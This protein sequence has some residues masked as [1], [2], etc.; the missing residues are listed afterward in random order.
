M[1]LSVGAHKARLVTVGVLLCA[2]MI[3]FG[4]QHYA[5]AQQNIHAII[6]TDGASLQIEQP[7]GDSVI[8]TSEVMLSGSVGQANQLEVYVD[9]QIDSIVSLPVE[10]TTF[11]TTVQL[12]PGTRTIKIVAIDAC[13]S[14]NA[15][16]SIVM[17]YQPAVAASTGSATPTQIEGGVVIG[18]TPVSA[19]VPAQNPIER[20]VVGPLHSLADA[21]DLIP[22]AG[23][24]SPVGV[25]QP[26][27]LA[28]VAGGAALV[29]FSS[30]LLGVE[31]INKILQLV[32]LR[33]GLRQGYAAQLVLVTLGLMAVAMAF[34]L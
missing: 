7:S 20:I 33:I 27:R 23:A 29:T 4:T 6:C 26:V 31:W 11:Q 2:G 16:A 19:E 15:T 32:A 21:L 13:Q 8:T 24:V 28:L 18:G 14:K 17:T 9:D 22:S 1:A 10:A 25:S 34:L 3:N 30:A 5:G 12:A